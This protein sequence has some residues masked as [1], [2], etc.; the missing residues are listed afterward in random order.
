ME[1]NFRKNY[2]GNANKEFTEGVK[3]IKPTPFNKDYDVNNKVVSSIIDKINTTVHFETN[4]CSVGKFI[5]I[6]PKVLTSILGYNAPV[7]AV[8][9]YIINNINWNSNCIKFTNQDICDFT[10]FKNTV[11]NEAINILCNKNIIAKTTIQSE[12]II[13]HNMIFYGTIDEFINAYKKLYGEYIPEKDIYGK[14]VIPKNIVNVVKNKCGK[15]DFSF[16]V[17]R[18]N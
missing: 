18:N 11:I 10:G 2:V 7:F 15:G 5:K 3:Y 1:I 17:S 13:N 8:L 14:V 9:T 16:S 12:Y 6:N 4:K